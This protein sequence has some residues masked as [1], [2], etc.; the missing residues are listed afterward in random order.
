MRGDGAE[1]VS[2][3]VRAY[4]VSER[5]AWRWLAVMRAERSDAILARK[6]RADWDCEACGTPLP[7]EV[8]I[9]R[10]YCNVKCRVYG[11][12]RRKDAE[13]TQRYR[14]RRLG[15]T[16]A[17]PTR[18]A[19]APGLAREFAPAPPGARGAAEP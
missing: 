2:A 9:R 19:A 8:T 11:Y 16:L 18:P 12:R 17:S 1:V 3:I 13:Q 6:R 4:D 15:P 14:E 7:A 5:T 10:K